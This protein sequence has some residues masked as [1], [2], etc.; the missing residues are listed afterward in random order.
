MVSKRVMRPIVARS[1]VGI[2]VALFLGGCVAT[3]VSQETRL[4][5]QDA[6]DALDAG[7]Y[8]VAV[9]RYERLL[10]SVGGGA[11]GTMM[12]LEYAHALLRANKPERALA[13]A[14]EIEVR[15]SGSATVGP[16]RLVAA[17]A[18]HELAERMVARAAPYEKARA[19]AR[20][21][22][23]RLGD[24][25]SNYPQYDPDGILIVRMR[26]LRELLAELEIEQLRTEMEAGIAGG[27]AAYILSEFSDTAA[28]AA[29]HELIRRAQS[30]E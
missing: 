14:R 13:V 24:V 12:S 15:G 29:A 28:V 26:R 9:R 3:P 18:E 30:A 22:F 7:D 11:V 23:R 5:Y 1:H 2:M 8:P 10:L 21:A 6:R 19:R 17:V 25:L 20:A 27:R 4:A 16:A